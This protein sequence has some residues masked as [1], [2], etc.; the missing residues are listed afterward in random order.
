M[1]NLRFDFGQ[2]SD[3]AMK[4]DLK[5]SCGDL[6]GDKKY[7]ENVMSEVCAKIPG[8]KFFNG[9]LMD[10]NPSLSVLKLLVVEFMP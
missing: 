4:I 1:L 8:Y 7:C 2:F 6:I 3:P 9:Y 10:Y 5:F